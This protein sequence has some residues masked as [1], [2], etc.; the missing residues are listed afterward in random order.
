MT[1]PAQVRR[2]LGRPL[3]RIRHQLE[4][5]F[6]KP[7]RLPRNSKSGVVIIA[8]I[9]EILRSGVEPGRIDL[10]DRADCALKAS[11]G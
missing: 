11:A 7:L 6:P 5:L 1:V 8:E 2:G 10:G 9:H 4:P 3:L